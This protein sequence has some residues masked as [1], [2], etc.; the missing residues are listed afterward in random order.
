MSR[1]MDRI[2]ERAGLG[3]PRKGPSPYMQ[4]MADRV[5]TDPERYGVNNP[6]PYVLRANARLDAMGAF[7]AVTPNLRAQILEEERVK[8][9][10]GQSEFA[11]DHW[12]RGKQNVNERSALADYKAGVM[13]NLG[14]V[15]ESLVGMAAPETA[16]RMRLAREAQWGTPTGV[17]GKVGGIVGMAGVTAA[18]VASGG[19]VGGMAASAGRGM[20]ISAGLFGM[21]GVGGVRANVARLRSEGRDI[22]WQAEWGAAVATGIF[23]AGSGA[24]SYKLT[25]GIGRKMAQ[26]LQKLAP[27]AA[28]VYQSGGRSATIRYMKTFLPGMMAEGTEESITQMATNA[29]DMIAEITPGLRFTSGAL[30]AGVTGALLAPFLGGVSMQ[31]MGS[32][33]AAAEDG[34]PTPPGMTPDPNGPDTISPVP[35][36]IEVADPVEGLT[37]SRT[38]VRDSGPAHVQTKEMYLAKENE[39]GLNRADRIISKVAQGNREVEAALYRAMGVEPPMSSDGREGS[40][41][42]TAR[43][44][45]MQKSKA[46]PRVLISDKTTGAV[47]RALRAAS[48]TTTAAE[49]KVQAERIIARVDKYTRTSRFMDDAL[50]HHARLVHRALKQGKDVPQAVQDQY[51]N[52][53]KLIE[54]NDQ[55]EEQRVAEWDND[56]WGADADQ[57]FTETDPGIDTRIPEPTDTDQSHNWVVMEDPD[58]EGYAIFDE[59]GAVMDGPFD[60]M[61]EADFELEHAQTE[62]GRFTPDTPDHSVGRVDGWHYS[63]AQP[64][65]P[66][67]N[68][69]PP[70]PPTADP[71]APPP[72]ARSNGALR[73]WAATLFQPI[74]TRI[75]QIDK[76]IFGRM[77]SFESKS[78]YEIARSVR[79]VTDWGHMLHKS[80]KLHGKVKAVDLR[81][82]MH[83]LLSNGRYNDAY[84]LMLEYAPDAETG[85]ALVNGLKNIQAKMALLQKRQV[86]AGI[87]VSKIENFFPRAVKDHDAYMARVGKEKQSSIQKKIDAAQELSETPLTQDD[88][89]RITNED[90]QG[91][92]EQFR[93]RSVRHGAQRTVDQITDETAD[94]YENYD[95]ALVQYM[96][97]TIE[98]IHAKEFFGGKDGSLQNSIGQYLQEQK[99]AGKI[100]DEQEQELRSMF[101]SR[102]VGGQRSP[103]K[104]L[105]K[106]RDLGYLSTIANTISAVTQA[107][108][109]ALSLVENGMVH[110]LRG[111]THGFKNRGNFNAPGGG[112]GRWGA[113][114]KIGVT[115]ASAEFGNQGGLPKFLDKMMTWSGFKYMDSLGKTLHLNSSF[116]QMQSAAFGMNGQH[117]QN[118][119]VVNNNGDTKAYK[120]MRAEWGEILGSDFD[121]TMA[122]LRGGAMTDNV[123]M[124]LFTKLS[125]IQPISLSEFPQ[126]YLDNPNGRIFYMLKSF[127]IKQFD[128]LKQESYDHMSKG[129]ANDDMDELL[130]G[131]KG[132]TKIAFVFMAFFGVDLLKDFL[133]QRETDID[134][135]DDK[136]L[137]TFLKMAG[138]SKY[139]LDKAKTEGLGAA[140]WGAIAP[141]TQW[142]TDPMKDLLNIPDFIMTDP[143]TGKRVKSL[144]ELRAYRNAPLMGKWLYYGLGHGNTLDAKAGKTARRKDRKEVRAE[145][146]KAMMDGDSSSAYILTE[147][148]NESKPPDMERLTMKQL[149]N[150]IKRERK[151]ARDDASGKT[152]RDE[153]RRLR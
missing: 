152:E 108:D 15:G 97:T 5:G 122:D 113:M 142:A 66:V 131:V 24:L 100:N 2:R 4:Q 120:K 8:D 61:A 121:Q 87:P 111:I 109:I 143:K 46:K 12:R 106:V 137:A 51:M 75:K 86:A 65:P 94:L 20:K 126:K 98:G 35:D 91:Y 31:S 37:G 77:M 32:R 151:K 67:R 93:E 39:K 49:A 78:A 85:F 34:S 23:E 50:N 110:G 74:S 150:A 43:I 10:G 116:V 133:M 69:N 1:Y 127:T 136:A 72:G 55:S 42:H 114:F 16:E 70:L 101:I 84:S 28:A 104:T 57:D 62:E 27:H 47:V 54:N 144:S 139:N 73:R 134:N 107:G 38:P 7:Q 6:H 81:V 41:D 60:T 96:A 79:Y 138:T 9:E 125:K 21:Q 103:H 25:S 48:N 92:G 33:Q 102:F 88:K 52:Q 17:A 40:S 18:T 58:T 118:G 141:P 36:P 145:A 148:Y 82:Q 22:S 119:K 71:V 44:A 53:G 11:V 99:D 83:K 124:V 14:G 128:Y 63:K 123:R 19:A 115:H 112:T 117:M 68:D 105:Q 147:H 26:N 140:A 153:A 3:S 135:I 80:F 56:A 30:E 146:I 130:K 129:F 45:Q 89:I 76:R 132:L 90:L 13:Q 149:R 95:V 29:A 59:N 64:E